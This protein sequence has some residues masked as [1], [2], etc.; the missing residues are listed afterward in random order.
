MWANISGN[1]MNYTNV[2]EYKEVESTKRLC[3][4]N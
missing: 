3:L 1:V 4:V 2:K